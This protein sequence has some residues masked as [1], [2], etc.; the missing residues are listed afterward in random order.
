M[1]LSSWDLTPEEYGVH[2]RRL[3]S[4][5]KGES[6]KLSVARND[7]TYFAVNQLGFKPYSWQSRLWDWIVD[8]KSVAACTA[9][10]IGKTAAIAIASLWAVMH[11][12]F[13]LESTK[14]TRIIIV[15]ATEEQSK[16]ILSDIREFMRLGDEN[17]Y[18]LTSR[19]KYDHEL[20]QRVEYGGIKDFFSSK[21]D[22][23]KNAANNTSAITFSNGCQIISL[24]PT[25]RS[26]G[27]T[28]SLLFVDEAAFIPEEDIFE[29]TLKHIVAMTGNQIVMTSTP[30]GRQGFFFQHFDPDDEA[31]VHIFH[32][33]WV[34]YTS[35]RLDNEN[36]VEERRLQEQIAIQQGKERQFQ[37]EQLA[38]FNS[39]TASFFNSEDVDACVKEKLDM[40]V[41]SNLPCDLAVDFG[42]RKVSRT[43]ITISRLEGSGKDAKIRLAYQK[44][45][46]P[47]DD[48]SLIS[49]IE[50]L[51]PKFNVQRIIF[52]ECP[53]SATASQ[54]AEKRG[55]NLT[56]FVPNRDKERKYFALKSWIRRGKVV[57]PYIDDLLREM[58]GLVQEDG[59]RYTK[60]HHGNGLLDDRIDSFMMST[61]F[62][63]DETG[64]FRVWD[65]DDV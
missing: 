60:I 43:V 14:K 3:E 38:S 24:P 10:Q 57:I 48:L 40:L 23:G 8:R 7:I 17:V 21:I 6:V 11:N 51:I 34:P 64:G 12:S 25:E 59:V 2:L 22:K 53:A 65:W 62:F 55:W 30:N 32:R 49:D 44:A 56:M 61:T 16:K 33:L 19:K 58:K 46:S 5:P 39:S 47:E 31:R 9:R 20:K 54:V 37:Q 18:N 29:S 36:L 35:M 1:S 42:V 4:V 63:T 15:S 26:R 52:E 13:P 27:Y 41:S 28:A 50:L 45:Y